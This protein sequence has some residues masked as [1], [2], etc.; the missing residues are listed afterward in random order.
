MGNSTSVTLR[1]L[2]QATHL[3]AFFGHPLNRVDQNLI[4][5][6]ELGDP[7]PEWLRGTRRLSDLPRFQFL[8]H[9]DN[10]RTHGLRPKEVA[11]RLVWIVENL[12]GPWRYSRGGITLLT[13]QDSVHYRLV[14]AADEG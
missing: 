4:R 9:G 13:E 10:F 12:S 1:V 5:I 7:P 2:R 6:A 14:W 3:E 11:A 8:G